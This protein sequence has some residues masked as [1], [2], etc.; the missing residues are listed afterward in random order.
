MNDIIK[1]ELEAF[2]FEYFPEDPFVGACYI[3]KTG[4]LYDTFHGPHE[5]YFLYLVSNNTIYY[6]ATDRQLIVEPDDI[7]NFITKYS[8]KFKIENI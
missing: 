3:L 5:K 8:D 4:E 6:C 7:S 2:G 1:N